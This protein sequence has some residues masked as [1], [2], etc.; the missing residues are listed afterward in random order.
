MCLWLLLMGR[1]MWQQCKA[2]IKQM[3]RLTKLHTDTTTNDG[4]A[5]S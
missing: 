3:V 2:G 4:V 5:N 1:I